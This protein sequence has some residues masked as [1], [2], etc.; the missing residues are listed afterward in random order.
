MPEK[1]SRLGRVPHQTRLSWERGRL[2]N[3]VGRGDAGRQVRVRKGDFEV[4]GKICV[5]VALN[6][7]ARVADHGEH[8]GVG[9]MKMSESV[10]LPMKVK[11]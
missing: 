10:S 3:E 6:D 11:A 2:Q 8:A 9:R 4:G 7:P 5:D 1:R